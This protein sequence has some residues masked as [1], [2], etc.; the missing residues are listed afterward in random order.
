MFKLDKRVCPKDHYITKI[1]AHFTKTVWTK[2]E[3]LKCSEK[4]NEQT[5]KTKDGRE[6]QQQEWTTS[7]WNIQEDC[8]HPFEW[9]DKRIS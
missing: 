5:N 3:L 9:I 2:D 4:N 6:A 8:I 1:L 7:L